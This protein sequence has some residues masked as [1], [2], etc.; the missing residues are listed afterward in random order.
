MHPNVLPDRCCIHS[1]R[2]GEFIAGNYIFIR[3]ANGR[4]SIARASVSPSG[5]D[6][7]SDSGA[8]RIADLYQMTAALLPGFDCKSPVISASER[9]H[10]HD[11]PAN[12][13]RY[14]FEW[15]TESEGQKRYERH[16]ET[17]IG[18]VAKSGTAI[19]RINNEMAGS[20]S[21]C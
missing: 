6:V 9:H 1:D 8:S 20:V 4:G 16:K 15:R 11:N 18:N 17:R 3:D 5:N 2:F 13:W 21:R 10:Y 7:S 12:G 14:I 19:S